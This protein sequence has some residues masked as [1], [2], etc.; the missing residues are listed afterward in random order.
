MT[1]DQ[2]CSS[3][4]SPTSSTTG[5]SRTLWNICR[6]ELVLIFLLFI[7]WRSPWSLRVVSRVRVITMDR[8][9]GVVRV[10]TIMG[11]RYGQSGHHGQD[12]QDGQEG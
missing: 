12:G 8:M 7:C 6:W 5:S 3:L 11:G 2:V 4:T 1:F 9:V 10:V